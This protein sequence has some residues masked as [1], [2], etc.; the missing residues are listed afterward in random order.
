MD[1][2]A[3]SALW[4]Q[5]SIF[6]F[7]GGTDMSVSLKYARTTA[8]GAG[9]LN[10]LGGISTQQIDGFSD[11]PDA[12]TAAASFQWN[13]DNSPLEIVFFAFYSKQRDNGS[14]FDGSVNVAHKFGDSLVLD[15]TA[16]YESLQEDNN[17]DSASIPH[18]NGF[19]GDLG[20]TYLASPT[21]AYGYTY[22]FKNDIGRVDKVDGWD[23][24]MRLNS[25]GGKSWVE[26][27]I[28]RDNVFGVA[29]GFKF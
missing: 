7:N 29:A 4:I 24:F 21:V 8:S 19:I 1:A 13:A 15:G 9:S 12:Y 28:A 26:F 2:A 25:M 6:W 18:A 17:V 27:N 14:V 23:A 5:P 16:R 3:G 20:L 11:R 10:I 22:T